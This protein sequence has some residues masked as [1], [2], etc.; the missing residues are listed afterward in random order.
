MLF[1]GCDGGST[2][3]E[4]MTANAQGV[5]V[6]RQSFPGMNLAQDG[7]ES[8]ARGICAHVQALGIDPA[9]LTHAAFGITGYGE[10]HTAAQ[11]NNRCR[12]IRTGACPLY[13]LQ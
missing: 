6:M 3:F 11:R 2:K 7:M 10:S 13:G 9:D 4:Y 5:C 1:L 12:P 8:F